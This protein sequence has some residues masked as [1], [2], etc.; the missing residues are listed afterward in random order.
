MHISAIRLMNE[1]LRQLRQPELTANPAFTR[2]AEVPWDSYLL[3][4]PGAAPMRFD[5]GVDVNVWVGPCSEVL[6]LP[7]EWE[8]LADL[9]SALISEIEIDVGPRQ[10]RVSIRFRNPQ[11]EIWYSTTQHF[12]GRRGVD[13]ELAVAGNF[14]AAFS[15]PPR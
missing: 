15:V 9:K 12:L 14:K 10:K 3:N 13:S 8:E 1:A 11:G 7:S 6:L 2:N 5:L 4:V